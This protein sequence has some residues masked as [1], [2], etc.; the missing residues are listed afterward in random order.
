V[1][2]DVLTAFGL[3]SVSVMVLC[4]ALEDRGD[5]FI[6]AFERASKSCIR[7]ISHGVSSASAARVG[8]NRARCTSPSVVI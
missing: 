4:Y 2:V 6:L 3:L 8:I 5:C 1:T 7:G